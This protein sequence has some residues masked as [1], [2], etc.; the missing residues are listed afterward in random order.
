SRHFLPTSLQTGL[1][2]KTSSLSGGEYSEGG[3]QNRFAYFL[4]F[5]GMHMVVTPEVDALAKSLHDQWKLD[6]IAPG[7]CTGEPEFAAL[8]REFKEHY[9]Y[10]GLGTVIPIP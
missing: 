5:G 9:V 3:K 10:A 4:L 7:H 8:R 2:P 6:G 1:T